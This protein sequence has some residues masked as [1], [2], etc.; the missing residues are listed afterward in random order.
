[1]RQFWP[2]F[3]GS[4][5]QLLRSCRQQFQS[6]DLLRRKQPGTVIDVAIRRWSIRFQV[7]SKLIVL[8]TFWCYGWLNDHSIDCLR[9]DYKRIFGAATAVRDT[10]R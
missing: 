4:A 8:A 9:P 2:L 3:G 6:V 7:S 5:C 10:T 1:M